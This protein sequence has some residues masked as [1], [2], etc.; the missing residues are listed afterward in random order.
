MEYAVI[1]LVLA[2]IGQPRIPSNLFIQSAAV[3]QQ[4]LG[5][6][7][8]YFGVTTRRLRIRSRPSQSGRILRATKV[9]DTITLLSRR[10]RNGYLHAATTEGISGWIL[11]SGVRRFASSSSAPTERAFSSSARASSG[12]TAVANWE[13]PE[14]VEAEDGTCAPI[15]L[16]NKGKPA[17]D[18]ATDLLKNRVDTSAAYH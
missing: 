15:G 17:P 11:S 18:P 16:G 8:G 12:D 4:A 10:A 13:K 3:E 9:G 6:Q 5:M 7:T 14:P 2:I 1:F